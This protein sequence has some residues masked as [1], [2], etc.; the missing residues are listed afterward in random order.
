MKNTNKNTNAE[1]RKQHRRKGFKKGSINQRVFYIAAYLINEATKETA[2]GIKDLCNLFYEYST[3]SLAQKFHGTYYA[4]LEDSMPTGDEMKQATIKKAIKKLELL[5]YIKI[6]QNKQDKE[7]FKISITKKGAQEY[8]K[9]K[10]EKK[11]KTKWDG[12]WRIIIFDILEN[13]RQIRNLLRRRLKWIGFKELQKSA[14]I[15]PYD[16]E[17]ETKEIL[18]VCNID[19]VGDVRFLTVERMNNDKDL[20]KEF[21]LN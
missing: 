10:I 2:Q 1:T 9:Y 12:K 17:K 5:D 7:K 13:Q 4:N 8:L 14:W 16:V 19:I 20:K 15:F 11:K 21:G 3:D 18:E 6:K